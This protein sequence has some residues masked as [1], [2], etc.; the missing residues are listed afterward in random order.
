MTENSYPRQLQP[1]EPASAS[2]VSHRGVQAFVCI[3][4]GMFLVRLALGYVP[5]PIAILPYLNVALAAGFLA[6]PVYAVFRVAEYPWKFFHGFILIATGVALQFGLLALDDRL[7]L[8]GSLR[9]VVI[10][11]SQLGLPLWC[12]G[13][14]VLLGAGVKDKNILIP[15]SIFLAVY[16]MFLVLTPVGPTSQLLKNT[17][18]LQNVGMSVPKAEAAPTVGTAAIQAYIGMA[19]I[20]FLAAFF[21]AIFRFQMRAKETMKALLWALSAYLIFVLGTGISMPALVP[22]GLVVLIVNRKEFKLSKDEWASTGVVA[23]LGIALLAWGATRP[24]PVEKKSAVTDQTQQAPASKPA[25][26]LAPSK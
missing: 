23:A 14:G 8:Q 12:T 5:F 15:V 2:L 20:V 24:K 26:P 17:K 3:F 25:T 4:L 7:K 11:L 16:D 13:L 10:G 19:D 22:I 6:L 21:V 1:N 9:G 18:I